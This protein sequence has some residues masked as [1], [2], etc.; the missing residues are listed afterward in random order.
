MINLIFNNHLL[1]EPS[2]SIK[3][4]SGNPCHTQAIFSDFLNSVQILLPS[5]KDCADESAVI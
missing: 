3:T 5:V 4:Q 2:K 1:S